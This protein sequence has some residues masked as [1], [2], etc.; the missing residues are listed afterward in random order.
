M[1]LE[2]FVN[3]GWVILERLFSTF[4]VNGLYESNII[5]K[6]KFGDVVDDYKKDILI[7]FNNFYSIIYFKFHRCKTN[8]CHLKILLI[9]LISIL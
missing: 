9:S 4:G 1:G 2:P 5:L 3:R 8:F 6:E 7:N